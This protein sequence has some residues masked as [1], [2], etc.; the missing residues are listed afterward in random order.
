MSLDGSKLIPHVVMMKGNTFCSTHQFPREGM[1]SCAF[2]VLTFYVSHYD[3]DLPCILPAPSLSLCPEL[4]RCS[5]H[6]RIHPRHLSTGQA[7]PFPESAIY[8]TNRIA[9]Q[10]IPTLNFHF[11]SYWSIHLYPDLYLNANILYGFLIL[12]SQQDTIEFRSESDHTWETEK[13]E[14]GIVSLPD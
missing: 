10:R 12:R 13:H 8:T 5:L 3:S 4:W 11:F 14:T 9:H 1:N 6:D 7:Y 2:L